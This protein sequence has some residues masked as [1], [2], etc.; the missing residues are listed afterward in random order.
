MEYPQASTDA[1]A[2]TNRRRSENASKSPVEATVGTPSYISMLGHAPM[3]ACLSLEGF[4][5]NAC[6]ASIDCRFNHHS[7]FCF[8][9]ESDSPREVEKI[10][11]RK[12]RRSS[13]WPIFEPT[14]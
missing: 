7:V 6:A 10:L 12:G 8:R 4:G 5:Q 11:V 3:V 9:A 2:R 14:R 13:V 1:K